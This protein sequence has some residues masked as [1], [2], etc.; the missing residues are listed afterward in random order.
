MNP[1]QDGL[2]EYK[3]MKVLK[4]D[5]RIGIWLNDE[6]GRMFNVNEN[7]LSKKWFWD[8]IEIGKITAVDLSDDIIDICGFDYA[9]IDKM[10]TFYLNKFTVYK[11]RDGSWDMEYDGNGYDATLHNIQNLYYINE[12]EELKINFDLY[13]KRNHK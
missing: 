6:N 1:I 4:N 10:D 7:D 9:D 3:T 5:V 13:G 8:Y 12:R 2:I 11:N